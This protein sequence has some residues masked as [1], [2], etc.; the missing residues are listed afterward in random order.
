VAEGVETREQHELLVSNGCDF[1]QGYLYSRA[2]AG[3]A[4]LA[5]IRGW[6][7]RQEPTPWIMSA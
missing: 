7:L 4:A 2:V 1:A 5:L 3:P 6:H